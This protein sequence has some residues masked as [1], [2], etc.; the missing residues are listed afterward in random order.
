M[1]LQPEPLSKAAFAPYGE[2]IEINDDNRVMP[3]NYGLTN[4]HHQLANVDIT[5]GRPI[6]S[7][8][9]TQQISLP[10]QIKVMERHPQGSQAFMPL[11]DNPY[12]VVVA[13]PGDFAPRHLRAFLASPQQ[14]VNYYRGTWHHYCLAL[15][16]PSDF[17]V[18]DRQGEGS[19]CDEVTLTD[20]VLI[21]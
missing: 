15:N 7:L 9:R 10:W 20:S 2:V 17:L 6:I 4:R 14:G 16:G 3:I 18:V 1:I 8:F 11:S 5:N 13:P 12:L 21:H 19:N